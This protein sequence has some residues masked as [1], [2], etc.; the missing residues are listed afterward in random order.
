M[1]KVSELSKEEAMVIN[2]MTEG[3]TYKQIA[4][5]MSKPLKWIATTITRIKRQYDCRSS[6]QLIAKLLRQEFL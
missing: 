4:D 5:R 6:V 1:E 3:Y 2:L